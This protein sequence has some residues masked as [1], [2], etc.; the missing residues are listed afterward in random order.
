MVQ[1]IGI[2]GGRASY[3]EQAALQL[4]PNSEIRYY[5]TFHE[6]FAALKVG[7]VN[8][9]VCAISNTHIGR[10]TESNVE[11]NTLHGKY[12][13]LHEIPLSISHS[14]LGMPGTTLAA[15]QNIYSQRPALDQCRETLSTLL[16]NAS[17]IETDDT[18][19]SAKLVAESSDPTKA[20]IAS[21]AAGE[22][23]GLIPLRTSVQDDPEN[24][25]NFIEI[26]LLPV[27]EVYPVKPELFD[28]SRA[29]V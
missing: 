23:Y 11:L 13:V 12:R 3:H 5:D 7:N 18:A 26:A 24:I 4:H 6:L 15:I 17:L 9:I 27:L 22:L 8:S 21:A 10:I 20:A 29:A 19:L 2:Q 1:L 25:T 16:P 14:L 28:K